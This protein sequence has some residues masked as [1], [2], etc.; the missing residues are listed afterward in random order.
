MM[1]NDAQCSSLA[2][3]DV[4]WHRHFYHWGVNYSRITLGCTCAFRPGR[5]WLLNPRCLV[6]SLASSR[7]GWRHLNLLKRLA[8]AYW[9]LLETHDTNVFPHRAVAV[10][11]VFAIFN[12]FQPIST[13]CEWTLRIV[14][15][16]MVFEC[17]RWGWWGSYR[18]GSHEDITD[19]SLGPKGRDP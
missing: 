3:A 15:H 17:F 13:L 4:I 10:D 7:I 12:P 18:P 14:G 16:L 5:S 8:L 6:T 19:G 2:H 9:C 11:R 1:P